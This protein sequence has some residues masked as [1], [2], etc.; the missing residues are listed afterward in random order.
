MIAR[1]SPGA[2]T[3]LLVAAVVII[4]SPLTVLQKKVAPC[5]VPFGLQ[6]PVLAMELVQT[7]N[8]VDGIVCA[9]TT[10][11]GKNRSNLRRHT[12][13]DLSLFIAAYVLLLAALARLGLADL[14]VLALLATVLAAAAGLADIVEDVGILSALGQGAY[15][16]WTRPAS[17]V[18]WACFYAALAALAPWWLTRLDW[19]EKVTGAALAASGLWGLWASLAQNERHILLAQWPAAVAMVGIVR[20]AWRTRRAAEVTAAP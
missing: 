10:A 15:L 1:M 17:L 2:V 19:I 11:E 18:K 5:E 16:S 4:G 7:R 8:Q 3:L 6:N 20:Y 12:Y 13:I 14:P 9:G